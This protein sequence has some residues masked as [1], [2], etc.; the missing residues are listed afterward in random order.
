MNK[1]LYLCTA[2]NKKTYM[3]KTKYQESTMEFA[4]NYLDK[5]LR[6]EEMV[7]QNVEAK[8][9][10]PVEIPANKIQGKF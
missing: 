8:R 2:V 5:L 10:K 1:K 4:M 7:R 6:M 3:P 9:Q